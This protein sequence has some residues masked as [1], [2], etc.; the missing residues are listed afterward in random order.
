[1]EIDQTNDKRT[2]LAVKDMSLPQLAK[3][4]ELLNLF[5][6]QSPAV[7]QV[8]QEIAT[9]LNNERFKRGRFS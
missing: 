6:Q 5:N 7:G 1:L 3:A 8:S 9:R 4:A 2:K